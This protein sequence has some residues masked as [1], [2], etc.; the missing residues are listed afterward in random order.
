MNY[1]EIKED[2][3]AMIDKGF[4]KFQGC[5][6]MYASLRDAYG[7]RP[8]SDAAMVISKAAQN[9]SVSQRRKILI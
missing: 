7:T 9:S 8:T 3:Y 1:K 2:I 5:E 6:L 4:L